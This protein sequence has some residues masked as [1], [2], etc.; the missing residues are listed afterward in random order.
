MVNMNEEIWMPITGYEGLYE[1]SNYGRVKSLARTCAT[2]GGGRKPIRERIIKQCVIK[3]YCNVI[4]CRGGSSHKHGLVH[5]LV[6][7][8]FI[9]NPENKPNIDHIN[10]IRTDNRVENLRWCTQ[11]ENNLNPITLG[12]MRNVKRKPHSDETKKKIGE[13]MKI[14]MKNPITHQKEINRGWPVIAY[15]DDGYYKEYRSTRFATEDTGIS[16]CNICS[17]CNGKRKTAGGLKWKYKYDK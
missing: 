9:P 6:A 17:C 11:S 2:R 13:I 15:N 8:A 7:Q 12:R 10:T 3:G 16:R 14:K 4:L 5:R 1:V